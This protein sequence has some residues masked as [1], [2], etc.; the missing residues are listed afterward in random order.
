VQLLPIYNPSVARITESLRG[1]IRHG[2][3]TV[4]KVR[5]AAT[6]GPEIASIHSAES[7]SVLPGLAEVREYS[8]LETLAFLQREGVFARMAPEVAGQFRNANVAGHHL[9]D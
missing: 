2:T 6:T 3:T 1:S 8:Q 7:E 5:M 9:V 4:Y